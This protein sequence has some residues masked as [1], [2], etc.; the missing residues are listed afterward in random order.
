[1]NGMYRQKK[2]PAGVEALNTQK[3][4]LIEQKYKF[5]A[6]RKKL[7]I[8]RENYQ[9]KLWEDYGPLPMQ[10]LPFLR[11]D[12]AYQASVREIDEIRE[13]IR[14]MGAVNPNAIEDYTRV[15][16]RYDN[17]VLQRED[18]TAAGNDLQIVIN[19]LYLV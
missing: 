7:E 13:R 19:G 8:S 6:S 14:E 5:I 1:M 10:T 18:L 4:L 9:N 17:L 3:D 16:E 12:F 15:R 2:Q 11:K